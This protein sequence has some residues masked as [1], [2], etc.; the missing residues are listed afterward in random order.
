MKKMMIILMVVVSGSM[1]GHDGAAFE[2]LHATSQENIGYCA[3]NKC[4]LD[5][6]YCEPCGDNNEPVER[7]IELEAQEID[8]EEYDNFSADAQ[9]PKISPVQQMAAQVFGELLIRYLSMKEMAG[10]YYQELKD[11][12]S[13]WYHTYIAKTN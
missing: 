5:Y 1:N 3:D 6:S 4:F 8:G 12:L 2:D 13:N 7:D 9:P 10:A 11:T